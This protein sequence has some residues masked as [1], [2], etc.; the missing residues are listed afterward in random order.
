MIEIK[1]TDTVSIKKGRSFG[2]YDG[3]CLRAYSYFGEKMPDIKTVPESTSCFVVTKDDGTVEYCTEDELI[4]KG[5][6][7]NECE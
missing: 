3:H 6:K 2:S 1:D 7:V 4:S 5:Y